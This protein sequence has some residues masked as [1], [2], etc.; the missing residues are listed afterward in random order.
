M[1]C[2]LSLLQQALS[3]NQEELCCQ[4]RARLERKSGRLLY[5]CVCSCCQ[6]GH[7][8]AIFLCFSNV[9]SLIYR[10]YIYIYANVTGRGDHEGHGQATR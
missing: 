2:S 1:G 5:F 8:E 10:I 3:G 4:P 9:E 7:V 6:T